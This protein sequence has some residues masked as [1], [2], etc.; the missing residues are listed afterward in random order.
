MFA[1]Q[2]VGTDDFAKSWVM[3]Y[4]NDAGTCVNEAETD[5]SL[6]SFIDRENAVVFRRIKHFS[7]Y[8]VLNIL[9]EAL[10]ALP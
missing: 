9:D 10:D 1:Y 6:G 5:L 7:G 2:A 8:I 4:C 3:K